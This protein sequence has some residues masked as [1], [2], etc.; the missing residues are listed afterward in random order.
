MSDTEVPSDDENEDDLAF[1]LKM[2][3][4]Q[5]PK[6]V[7]KKEEEE[8]KAKPK[9]SLG[10]AENVHISGLVIPAR[11]L[12]FGGD[13]AIH[14]LKVYWH[15]TLSYLFVMDGATRCKVTAKSAPV[16]AWEKVEITGTFLTYKA[17]RLSLDENWPFR[18]GVKIGDADKYLRPAW[19]AYRALQDPGTFQIPEW[20]DDDEYGVKKMPDRQSYINLPDG[21]G[22]HPVHVSIPNVQIA[23]A[24]KKTM[25][26]GKAPSAGWLW[27]AEFHVTVETGQADKPHIWD[28]AKITGSSSRLPVDATARYLYEMGEDA[29]KW[30]L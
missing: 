5:K 22:G 30:A 7:S 25:G 13:T 24:L 1:A 2:T 15:P 3:S 19:N 14:G 26:S 18:F 10:T 12:K 21:Y 6:K 23:T 27:G 9:P 4:L 20:P 16:T 8:D 28:R 17:T 11:P 29:L